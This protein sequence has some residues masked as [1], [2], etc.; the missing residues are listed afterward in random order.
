VVAVSIS[1][2]PNRLA[3]E[4]EV[5]LAAGVLGAAIGALATYMGGRGGGPAAPP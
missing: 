4:N 5:A 1:T 3:S 2:N